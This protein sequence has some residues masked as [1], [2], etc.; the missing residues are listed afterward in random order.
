M[1]RGIGEVEA[2]VSP[3]TKKKLEKNRIFLYSSSYALPALY[4]FSG[5]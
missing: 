5:K 4:F 1:E 2:S 3:D